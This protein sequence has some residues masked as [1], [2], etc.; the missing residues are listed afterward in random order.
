MEKMRGLTSF[1]DAFHASTSAAS[2][3]TAFSSCTSLRGFAFVE[4]LKTIGNS[5]FSSCK[6]LGAL[7]IP[8]NVESI[9]S[10]A[11]AYC[12]GLKEITILNSVSEIGNQAFGACNYL[13][14]YCEPAERPQ[15]WS[16]SWNGAYNNVY[17]DY[18]APDHIE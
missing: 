18:F 14:I 9:G 1:S 5:A 8:E 11:F 2:V 16:E 10:Y 12:K 6:S 13:K 4:G 15:G 3:S 17:W 7:T